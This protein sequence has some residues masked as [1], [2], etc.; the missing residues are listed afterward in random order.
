MS[1]ALLRSSCSPTLNGLQSASG[2][3]KGPA[4][5]PFI[6][7]GNN[8]RCRKPIA[9]SLNAITP[10]RL[11]PSAAA[12]VTYELKPAAVSFAPARSGRK[13]RRARLCTNFETEDRRV[14]LAKNTDTLPSVS[15]TAI[16][17][18]ACCRRLPIPAR[19]RFA[20]ATAHR[21]SG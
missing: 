1:T 18:R 14:E 20:I 21:G 7:S 12:R 13:I 6:P 5:V 19:V 9:R 16:V 11:I 8:G 3:L 15:T 17:T 4:S 10:F 2:L